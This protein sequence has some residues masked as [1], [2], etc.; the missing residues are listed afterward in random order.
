MA[1]DLLACDGWNVRFVGAD[2]P[3]DAL[4]EL[5]MRETPIF[6]GLSAALPEH[7]PSARE[8]VARLRRAAPG[9]KIIVGGRAVAGHAPPNTIDADEIASSATDAVQKVRAW[10]P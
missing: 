4:L 6:V 9:T 2:T 7:L 3:L 8:A 5:V 10:K 1:A